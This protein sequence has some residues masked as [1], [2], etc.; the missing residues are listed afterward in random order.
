MI[1]KILGN[2]TENPR[3]SKISSPTKPN[4]QKPPNV[5]PKYFPKGSSLNAMYGEFFLSPYSRHSISET[6]HDSIKLGISPPATGDLDFCSDKSKEMHNNDLPL[7]NLKGNNF[8]M[9]IG[10]TPGD[11]FSSDG[12]GSVDNPPLLTS[13]K[14]GNS[15]PL[16]LTIS[17]NTG[18]ALWP[19]L[20]L[21]HCS[22]AL[23]SNDQNVHHAHDPS[24]PMK[25]T[26]S[27][28]LNVVQ[29]WV[30]T[31]EGSKHSLNK[32]ATS[33]FLTID[34][35]KTNYHFSNFSLTHC[36]ESLTSGN[37]TKR[38]HCS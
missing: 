10:L 22:E 13:R 9:A 17:H 36:T 25:M 20:P 28:P 31:E 6:T 26:N 4:I 23:A 21:T 12:S 27:L 33:P 7:P 34:R 16:P 35:P 24:L 14:L 19:S 8:P 15:K 30:P 2:S 29:C 38:P 32:C 37:P 1:R 5:L 3:C 11:C 18:R